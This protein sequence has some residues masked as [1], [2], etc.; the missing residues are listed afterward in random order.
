MAAVKD[1][2]GWR[3]VF[4][5]RFSGLEGQ[6][7]SNSREIVVLEEHTPGG[8]F[9][10]WKGLGNPEHK[11]ER[12]RRVG[13]PAAVAT[14]DGRVHLFVRN[15]GK[16]LSSRV[17]EANGK[18]G[19]WQSLHGQEIQ[20]GLTVALDKQGRVHVFGVGRDTV[21]HWS[22]D[23]TGKPVHEMPLKG[24]P[25]PG[26][27]PVAA[28]LGSDDA[29]TVV[30]RTPE[31]VAPSAYRLTGGENTSQANGAGLPGFAGYGPLAACTV[32]RRGGKDA[33]M[34]LGRAMNGEIQLADT[35]SG[36]SPVHAPPST[37]P[38]APPR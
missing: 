7:R 23:D 37:S 36:D 13:L 22:Q 1:S 20:E 5:L 35:D 33:L 19:K 28:A 32:P 27:D 21:H 31:A 2:E 3:L 11:A 29:L 14:S 30:Y 9:N 25:G 34:L 17:R 24:L 4:A 10:A 15:A 26:G 18:W 16:G 12:G 38:W 6:G 8:S